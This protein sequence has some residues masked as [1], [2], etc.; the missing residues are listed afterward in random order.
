MPSID[1]TKLDK[2]RKGELR[3]TQIFGLDA[4][5]I[6]S[7]LLCG[8]NFLMQGRLDDA[9]KIFEGLTVLDPD[10]PYLHTA[11]GSI[12]QQQNNYEVAIQQYSRALQLFPEDISALT[13]RGEIHLTLGRF[14]EAAA[15]LK[16]AIQLDPHRKKSS[17]NRAR[18]LACITTETLRSTKQKN[19]N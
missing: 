3:F 8:H 17:S 4:N 12:Y 19:P 2:F 13:N 18:F 10:D 9:K 7:L 6:A 1:K 14:E 11:L 16:K 5:H 15:D